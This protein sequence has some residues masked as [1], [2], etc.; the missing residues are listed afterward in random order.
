[1]ENIMSI[2]T[3]QIFAK[4]RNNNMY[5]VNLADYIDKISNET[6]FDEVWVWRLFSRLSHNSGAKGIPDFKTPFSDTELRYLL[7]EIFKQ[8]VQKGGKL[9]DYSDSNFDMTK[10]NNN[11]LSYIDDLVDFMIKNP[12]YGQDGNGFWFV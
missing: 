8:I 6:T 9:E 1:M 5:Y 12:Q 7:K 4:L 2:N 3:N 10:V 11:D